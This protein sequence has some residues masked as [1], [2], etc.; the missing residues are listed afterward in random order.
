MTT[1]TMLKNIACSIL[2]TGSAM[3][4]AMTGAAAQESAVFGQP[5]QVRTGVVDSVDPTNGTI[6][7]D[8]RQY[9]LPTSLKG[10]AVLQPGMEIRFRYSTQGN[11]KII[12]EVL[13]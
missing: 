6:V 12:T 3:V 4:G 9:A 8:D 11:E 5:P 7:I 10:L 1:S 2:I 13:K